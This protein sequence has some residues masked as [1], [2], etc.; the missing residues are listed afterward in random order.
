MSQNPEAPATTSAPSAAAPPEV[1]V[2]VPARNEEGSLERCLASVLAQ[3]GVDF[4]VVVVDNGSTD[5]T[6]QVLRRL[7]AAD[8][9][10]VVVDQ[11]RPSI[12][13][14]LNAGLARARGR[15]LVRVDA[16]ST[17]SEG[18]LRHAVQRLEEG[19]WVAV[20]GRK[21]AVGRSAAGQAVAA[22]LNSKLAVG[23]STYHWGTTEQVVDHIPF[24]CYPTALVRELGGW[25]DGVANNED[26]EF[27]QRLRRHGDILFDPAL[28]IDWD[29]RESVGALYRQYRRYGTGKPGV[30]LRHPSSLKLRHLAPPALVAY[31]AVAALVATRRPGLAAAAVAPYAAGVLAVG[32]RISRDAPD[33]AAR[34]QVPLALAAMQVGWGVGFWRGVWSLL[35]RRAST[36]TSGG[37]A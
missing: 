6:P 20:G 34:S 32:S 29:S 19:R 13:A 35:G 7:A 1:T 30:A 2:L 9:R 16:H 15:F 4:E 28:A 11:P 37:A 10:V 27:D 18:Y 31:L 5:A 25:D 17:I 23:G 26:F 36:G 14:S 22:V 24:G 33:G 3:E 8:P 12:P 21:K